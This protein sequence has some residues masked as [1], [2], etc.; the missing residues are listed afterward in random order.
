MLEATA[1]MEQMRAMHSQ[2]LKGA[3]DDYNEKIEKLKGLHEREMKLIKEELDL[4]V[5]DNLFGLYSKFDL[6]RNKHRFEETVQPSRR[7]LG[8]VAERLR[9]TQ[10][11]TE[12]I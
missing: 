7:I 6:D 3:T 5:N 11:G 1:Q 8:S 9:T 12:T 2:Q 10:E 4:Q